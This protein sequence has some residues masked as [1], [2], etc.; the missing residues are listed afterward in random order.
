[1]SPDDRPF[2]GTSA[3]TRLA[4]YASVDPREHMYDLFDFI[5]VIDHY[6][7]R[8][9]DGKYDNFPVQ[10]ARDQAAVRVWP[11]I[12]STDVESVVLLGRQTSVAMNCPFDYF[13]WQTIREENYGREV[14]LAVSPHPGGTVM[15]WN[16]PENLKRGCE[17]L[18]GLA[19]EAEAEWQ[20]LRALA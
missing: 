10:F 2:E 9:P 5:N 19:A 15:W 16:N 18:S 11:H 17:F 8:A 4:K 7:G 6:P 3:L 14:R 12:W 20:R 1:M 13:E